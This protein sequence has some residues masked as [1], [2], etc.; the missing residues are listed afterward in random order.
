MNKLTHLDD[1]GAARMVD[2]GGKP[3]TSRSATATGRIVMAPATLAAIRDGSGP[4][5][6]VLSRS[7]R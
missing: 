5:G 7:M 6:D 1:S 4:K 2:V 3:E